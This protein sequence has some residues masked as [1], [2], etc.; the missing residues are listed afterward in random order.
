MG[1]NG[2]NYTMCYY[3]TE[4]SFIKIIYLF[5]KKPVEILNAIKINRNLENAVKRKYGIRF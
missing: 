5:D 2:H 1:K 3:Q 4:S